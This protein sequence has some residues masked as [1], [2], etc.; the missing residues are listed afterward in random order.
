MAHEGWGGDY[1]NE[2]DI[3]M[4]GMASFSTFMT[5]NCKGQLWKTW[6]WQGCKKGTWALRLGAEKGGYL[7]TKGKDISYKYVLD[8]GIWN[9]NVHFQP[10][11]KK[12][13]N[14]GR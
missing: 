4:M 6:E 5:A 7:C 10:N 11:R 12:G 14:K 3:L 1:M 13:P 9:K 8:Q 2:K